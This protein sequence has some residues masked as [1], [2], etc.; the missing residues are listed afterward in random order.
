MRLSEK[1]K[2]AKGQAKQEWDNAMKQLKTPGRMHRLIRYVAAQ[3]PVHAQYVPI[4]TVYFAS[5]MRRWIRHRADDATDR[6]V[7]R[8]SAAAG[9]CGARAADYLN[10]CNLAE[11]RSGGGSHIPAAPGWRSPPYSSSRQPAHRHGEPSPAS[12]PHEK[13]WAAADRIPKADPTGWH[14]GE[15]RS[16]PGRRAVRQRCQREARL[17]RRCRRH[18]A[19]D[20]LP[21]HGRGAHL[22]GC[23]RE[24]WWYRCGQWRGSR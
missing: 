23:L 14:S 11:G 4:G 17:R 5:S 19:E 1:T 10:I 3:L 12:S 15:G 2:K 16:D 22:G 24:R 7:D 6:F 21:G 9:Q 20:S 8:R 18:Y 13:K